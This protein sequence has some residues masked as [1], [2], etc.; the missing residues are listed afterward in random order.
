MKR[1][2][3]LMALLCAAP[4]TAGRYENCTARVKAQPQQA[5]D[6]A[7]AWRAEGGGAAAMHC[8]ALAL[9]AL[10]QPAR[11]AAV[12]DAAG[13]K[14][15][16]QPGVAADIYAQAGNAW[17]LAGDATRAVARLTWALDRQTAAAPRTN[18]LIDR[19]RAYAQLEDKPRALAD[20]TAAYA[21]APKNIDTLLLRA[22]LYLSQGESA[23]ARA[24][25]AAAAALPMD[26]DTR[27]VFTRLSAKAGK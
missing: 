10:G 18:M 20:L 1:I 23:K 24:D 16:T 3:A 2:F 27:A 26:A 8:Q 11:A 22:E 4:A 7:G 6:Q 9:L 21:A 13:E 19:A 25:L 17:L 5:L 15:E 14:L 12:L